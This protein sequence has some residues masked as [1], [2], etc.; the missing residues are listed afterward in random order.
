MSVSGESSPVAIFVTVPVAAVVAGSAE[1]AL[2]DE[3]FASPVKFGFSVAAATGGCDVLDDEAVVVGAGPSPIGAL[4]FS[5][6]ATSVDAETGT[7]STGVAVSSLCAA[8]TFVEAA[9]AF[10]SPIIRES[11]GAKDELSARSFL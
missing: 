8:F 1:A 10:G 11:L 7:V 4:G 5:L 9:G 3:P 6:E 2:V